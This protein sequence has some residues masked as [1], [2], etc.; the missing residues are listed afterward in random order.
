M[1]LLAVTDE[2][3]D[4]IYSPRICSRFGDVDLL[5]SCGDLP[6]SYLEYII[7]M[8][9]VPGFF[10]HGNHDCDEH[11]SCGHI[12]KAPGGW[13][14]LDGRTVRRKGVIIGGLEGSIRYRPDGVHQYTDMQMAFRMWR[15]TPRLLLNHALYGRYID[16]LITHSPPHGIHDGPDY[17]HR[18]F[19]AFR[20]FMARFRPTYLLHGHK[21]IYGLERWQTTFIDT[22]V[23]NVFPFRI[24]EW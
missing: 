15:M 22:Q 21:H 12:L 20:S 24:I 23:I 3:V 2:V 16:I 8:L 10:V 18:G 19:K 9:N 4:I 14:N 13:T 5:A 17:A 6:F 1:K 7:S 11:T